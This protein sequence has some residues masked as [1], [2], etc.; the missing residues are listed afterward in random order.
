ML[1]P[2]IGLFLAAQVIA[3]VPTI[4][5]IEIFGLRKVSR[6]KVLKTL[7]VN[8]GDPLPPS[9][10]QLEDALLATDG[11]ARSNVEAFCCEAGKAILYVGVEERGGKIFSLRDW[12]QADLQLPQDIVDAYHDLT[13]AMATAAREGDTGE[14]ID[15]GHS[16]MKNVP[17]RVLQTRFAGF[18]ELNLEVLRAVLRESDD[19]EQRAIAAY[20]IGYAPRKADVVNDLQL[21][22]RDPDP[23]VRA[24]ALRALRPILLLAQKDPDLGVKVELTWVVEMLNSTVLADRLE[25]VKM[26][27]LL[28]DHSMPASTAAQIRESGL[29]ALEEMA[30]WRYLQHALPA[31]LLLGRVAGFPDDELEK[32]WARGE[33]KAKLE[34]IEKRLKSKKQ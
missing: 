15:Q 7:G 22:L 6:E 34:E 2:A 30:R 4:G 33:N 8:P 28:T 23:D 24:N 27:M 12:P 5:E 25:S 21:A 19:D 17:A 14:D 26:L 20:V 31:Y 3:T 10:V 9:K 18:A 13:I 1:A 29:P 32:A 11:I 16:L